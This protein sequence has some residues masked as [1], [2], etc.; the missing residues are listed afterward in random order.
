MDDSLVAGL[1]KP[2][3]SLKIALADMILLHNKTDFSV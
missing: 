1:L 3:S 2:V